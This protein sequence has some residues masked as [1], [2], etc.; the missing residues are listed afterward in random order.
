MKSQLLI[1]TDS[2]MDD[3]IA[4][5]MLIKSNNTNIV[6]I[7]TVNGLVN[8]VI[9][10]NNL[11]RILTYFGTPIDICP[12]VTQPISI[13]SRSNQ[14]PVIDQ[15][16]STELSFLKPILPEIFIG[17]QNSKKI[18]NWIYDKTIRS[19][20]G[21]TIA[22]LGP[23]TNIATTIQKYGSRFTSKV[24][25][26][27]I[28]GGTINCLGNVLPD[29]NAEYNFYLDPQ[30]ADIVVKSAIRIDLVTLDATKLVPVTRNLMDTIAKMTPSSKI[31]RVIRQIIMNDEND[32]PYFY[33]PL[34]AEILINP[35]MGM[36]SKQ[37]A[38]KV[39]QTGSKQGKLIRVMDSIGYVKYVTSVNTNE[40]YN[41]IVN[42]I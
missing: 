33:D 37:L 11:G 13:K 21:L 29:K 28:M 17:S 36:Y 4:I 2:G 31:G 15:K 1:D 30:A 41:M 14:F 12:G 20:G 9:G 19:G 10:A 38:Y 27:I 35:T 34:V 8:P 26:I 5:S 32:F 24:N 23:L 25:K 7:S 16:R 3:I 18:E 6:G 42:V 22:A 40:F 39:I